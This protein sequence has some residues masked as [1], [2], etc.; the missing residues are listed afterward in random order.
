METIHY[1][2]DNLN[3]DSIIKLISISIEIEIPNNILK[4]FCEIY[5][6][7]KQVKYIS[8]APTIKALLPEK[9]IYTDLIGLFIPIGYDNSKYGLLL[10]NDVSNTTTGVILKNKS[11]VK[12]ELPKYT[13]KM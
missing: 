3:I 6:L 11:H 1:Y 13:E 2:L 5:I 7:A 9:R 4:F 12:V 10:I 8:N